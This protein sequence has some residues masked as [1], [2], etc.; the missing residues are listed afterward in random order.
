MGIT[1]NATGNPNAKP[2]VAGTLTIKNAND[3]Y[4][5]MT[6]VQKR[7]QRVKKPLNYNH[8]EI[9][10]QLLRAKK[11]QS[12]ATT[13]TRAKGK[14]AVLQR[15]AGTG[16]YDEKEI[17]NAIAHARRMVRC[18]QMKVRNLREEEREQK[19]N[20]NKSG[21]KEQQIRNEVKRRVVEKERELEQKMALE[22]TQAVIEE[23][24]KR[25]EMIQKRR[26][27]RNQERGKI[28]EADM[29]YIKGMMEAGKMPGG[30]SVMQSDAVIMDLSSTAAAI[31][32]IAML[33]QQIQAETE[34]EVAA[35]M[36][37]AGT[38]LGGAVSSGGGSGM[39]GHGGTAIAENTGAA[40]PAGGVNIFV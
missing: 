5:R 30:T 18:A 2:V 28:T 31:N 3:P 13:L 10:G 38:D 1:I 4:V 35:E 17:S 11:A 16:Q 37:M 6:A 29:K 22:Q 19:A 27:H 26:S 39:T 12:A 15:A 36:A 24:K 14:L 21:A 40:A 23:K 20:R 8:R 25:T 33:E 34:A 9:S 32:E 7:E